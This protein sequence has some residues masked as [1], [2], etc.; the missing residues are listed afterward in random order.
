MR[1][2]AV[3]TGSLLPVRIPPQAENTKMHKCFSADLKAQNQSQWENGLVKFDIF[4]LSQRRESSWL[5]VW[6][7]SSLKRLISLRFWAR[8]IKSQGHRIHLKLS[9]HVQFLYSPA[10]VLPLCGTRHLCYLIFQK[11][12]VGWLF[13]AIFISPSERRRRELGHYTTRVFASYVW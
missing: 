7:L 12:T 10:T 5:R 1:K 3:K 2:L 13:F 4:S 8:Y 9:C 11:K 6:A